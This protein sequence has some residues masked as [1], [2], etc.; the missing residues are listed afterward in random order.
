MKY[1]SQ[2]GQDEYLDKEIF[3]KKT[4]GFFVEVGANDGVL[5][6]NSLFF[7]KNRSWK[8]LLIEPNPE[9]YKKL[10]T[11]RSSICLNLAISD[12]EGEVVFNKIT[13]YGQQ[14]SGI[15]SK[16]DPKHIDRIKRTI[17]EFGGSQ[18]QVKIQSKSLD[19]IFHLHNI[20]K[21]DFISIDTEG[22][23]LDILKTIDFEKVCIKALIVENNYSKNDIYEFLNAK[24]Y[25]LTKRLE[26]DEIY[27][28][29]SF[30]LNIL[31][32]IKDYFKL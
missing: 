15:V 14:L 21:I 23:E 9:E 29:R 17:D 30:V 32:K 20:K 25:K 28:K 12:T 7:E 19:S 26:M 2:V 4:N 11:N 6:S 8:G 1:F 3:N 31:K 27:V 13:G 10:I 24:G 16:Y 5:F 22:G 18:E